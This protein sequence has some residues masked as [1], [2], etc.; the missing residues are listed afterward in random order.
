MPAWPIL[1][2]RL[3]VGAKRSPVRTPEQAA[4]LARAIIA[5]EAT[6]AGRD[7]GLRGADRRARRRAGWAGHWSPAAR[8]GDPRHAGALRARARRAS[9]RDRGR[10]RRTSSSRPAALLELVNGGGTG[11]LER[12]AAEAAVTELAAGSG[13]YGPA[14]FDDYR[15]FTP[16][17]AAMFALPVVR[18]PGRGVVTALGGGYLASGPA[19]AA[20]LPAAAPAGGLRARPPGGRR[21]GADAAARRRRR[22]ALRSAIAC[23]CAT[24][25]PASCASA[26]PACTCSKASASSIRCRPTAVRDSASCEIAVSENGSVTVSSCQR[27]ADELDRGR[28][29]PSCARSSR[30]SLRS[31]A[32]PARRA[33]DEAAEWLA[34]RL[35]AID[36]V[37]VALEDEPSWGIFPPTATGLGLLGALGAALVLSGR[38]ASGALL[39]AATLRRHRRRGAERAAHPAPRWCAAGAAPST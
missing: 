5:R 3:R 23:T 19:D 9:R 27:G 10:R 12:T 2:G 29:R 18:R 35:R 1:G 17:P 6:A 25:R 14:L 38:R 7:H 26:S 16:R 4:A 37:Q 36:G 30:R 8:S 31:T 13:L 32:R 28:S 33:S 15:A 21:R 22:R 11:S 24:P 34:E 39:A 20:R